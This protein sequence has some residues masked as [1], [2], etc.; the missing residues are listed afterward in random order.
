MNLTSGAIGMFTCTILGWL[1]LTPACHIEKGTSCLPHGLFHL[2]L[3][4]GWSFA[5]VSWGAMFLG[6]AQLCRWWALIVTKADT[7]VTV[8]FSLVLEFLQL[9]I[10]ARQGWV[11]AF[12]GNKVARSQFQ[13]NYQVP[14]IF[15]LAKESVWDFRVMRP[16]PA[17][18]VAPSEPC[19]VASVLALEAHSHSGQWKWMVPTGFGWVDGDPHTIGP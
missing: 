5:T 11:G 16:R 4:A 12:G 2:F 3:N 17:W 8:D 1:I 7:L 6:V 19:L 15:N 14:Q 10:P 18:S 9:E 13:H